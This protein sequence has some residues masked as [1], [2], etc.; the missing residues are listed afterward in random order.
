LKLAPLLLL[1]LLA[2]G[3]FGPSEQDRNRQGPVAFAGDLV[4]V[5]AVVGG[6]IIATFVLG[7]VLPATATTRGVLVV[8]G[9]LSLLVLGE[10]KVRQIAS[11]YRGRSGAPGPAGTS[12]GASANTGESS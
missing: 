4:L 9:S 7:D 1:K 5:V 3:V 8:A 2:K 12:G 10:Y 6:G 11:L